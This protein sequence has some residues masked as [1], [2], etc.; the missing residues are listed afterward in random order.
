LNRDLN[1]AF[2]SQGYAREEL[3]AEIASM[4]VGSELGIGYDPGQH[5]SYA[6]G[7]VSILKDQPLEIFR[8][9]ADAEKIQKYLASLEQQQSLSGAIEEYER[10][11]NGPE[12]RKQLENENP[13]L[14]AARDAA[15]IRRKKQQVQRLIDQH[16]SQALGT[17]QRLQIRI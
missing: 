10:Q 7:W 16:Q 14:V 1:H 6:A 2:G 15:I 8:A 3:R 17:G 11:V 9:A 5:A 4:I 13:G 12:S